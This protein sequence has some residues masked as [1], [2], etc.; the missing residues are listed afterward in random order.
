M[1]FIGLYEGQ[2][3]ENSSNMGG[4]RVAR[5]ANRLSLE[6]WKRN[7]LPDPKYSTTIL[8]G[9]MFLWDS[10]LKALQGT[11]EFIPEE[12]RKH[13]LPGG[14]YFKTYH[15][16]DTG[17]ENR[18]PIWR[19]GAP[20]DVQIRVSCIF[21]TISPET[22]LQRRREREASGVAH[23]AT[24]NSDGHMKTAASKQRNFAT[25]CRELAEESIFMGE[26]NPIG[27]LEVNVEGMSPQNVSLTIESYIKGLS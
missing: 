19:G 16:I 12:Q 21:L 11:L 8:D 6:Y 9:E 22:S 4:D 7:I 2:G 14:L 23:G 26:A 5:H 17:D 24:I 13:F 20:S 10:H 27:Y 15:A 18:F 25:K 1:A 3:L